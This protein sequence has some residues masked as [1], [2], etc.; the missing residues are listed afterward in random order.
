MCVRLRGR[1]WFEPEIVHLRLTF[2]DKNRQFPQIAS[3]QSK[4]RGFK[5][6]PAAACPRTTMNIPLFKSHVGP[7][8]TSRLGARLTGSQ[9]TDFFSTSLPH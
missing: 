5:P 1:S 6:A 8:L 3:F 7:K 2:G 9:L 4:R